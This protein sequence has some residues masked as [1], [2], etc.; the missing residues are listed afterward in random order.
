[1]EPKPVVRF[2]V[3]VATLL[4]AFGLRFAA[5]GRLPLLPDEAYYWLWS[6]HLDWAYYDHPAGV[7]LL[8]RLSTTLGGHSEFGIR[9]LNAL[10]GTASVALTIVVGR[11]MSAQSAGLLAGVTVAVGAPFLIT[12][13]FVYTDALFVFLM[14]LNLTSFLA[15]VG[16]EPGTGA[17]EKK[18]AARVGFGVTLALLLNTKY[19][20]YLYAAGLA[21]WLLWER[22]RLLRERWFWQAVIIAAAGLLPVFVWNAAHDWVSFRWQLAHA[23]SVS[24]GASVQ[25]YLGWQ[26]AAN[27]GH[28]V[29]YHTWPLAIAAVVGAVGL[30]RQ[31]S[32]PAARLV[33]WLAVMLGLPMLLS[34]AS[35]PRNL[36]AGLLFLLLGAGI[37]GN[38]LHQRGRQLVMLATTLLLGLTAAYGAG[39]VSAL[40]CGT[41]PFHSSVTSEIR[42]DVAGL[43]DLIA[44]A[45]Y[46]P[47]GAIV[48]VDYS[49]A[50]Q[51]W[52]YTGR[53]VATGWGQYQLWE[54]PALDDVTV[55]SLDYLPA[56]LIDAQLRRA[57][58]V[59]EGPQ[60]VFS[61]ER[62]FTWWRARGLRWERAELLARLDFLDLWEASR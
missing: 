25:P 8:L 38:A 41:G 50:G 48:A 30:I 22:R 21:G 61:A 29:T 23:V 60:H 36:T 37:W 28:A 58:M 1:M 11:Q 24:P 27:V 52:Y 6:R 53:R 43:Q 17:A 54:L 46:H 16:M 49:L 40:S 44:V 9:W 62:A 45:A 20:A 18:L 19:T 7:A 13:R 14:L 12:A 10:L 51:L 26:W 5:L 32:A 47:Q 42:R 2:V 55:L 33:G 31:R 56:P 3:P 4:T 35:S 34:P 57:F 59:V 15:L 39:T